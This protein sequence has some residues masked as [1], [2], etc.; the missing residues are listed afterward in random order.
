M[1]LLT[2]KGPKQLKLEHRCP[3]Q[4]YINMKQSTELLLNKFSV[5]YIYTRSLVA[6]VVLDC[7]VF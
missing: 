4:D 3:P 6:Q 2:V 7:Q 5:L 1:I